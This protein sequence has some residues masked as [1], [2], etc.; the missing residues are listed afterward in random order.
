MRV[1]SALPGDIGSSCERLERSIEA[2]YGFLTLRRAVDG[3]AYSYAQQGLRTA[4]PRILPCH[5]KRLVDWIR[6]VI[7]VIAE[8]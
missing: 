1:S 2:S 4:R 7:R 3:C 6:A 5:G 8:V